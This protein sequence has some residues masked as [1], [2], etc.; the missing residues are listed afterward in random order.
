MEKIFIEIGAEIKRDEMRRL[1]ADNEDKGEIVWIKIEKEDD[2]KVVWD[3]KRRLKES[4][5]EDL[6]WKSEED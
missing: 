5:E 6:T 4:I 3:W 1:S 2:K